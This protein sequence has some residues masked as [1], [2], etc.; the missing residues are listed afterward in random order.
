MKFKKRRALVKE[1]L[2]QKLGLDPAKVDTVDDLKGTVETMKH[3]ELQKLLALL[4][5][6]GKGKAVDL[7]NKLREYLG[8]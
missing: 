2:L 7:R 3:K 4:K 8:Y 5:L 1:L 6:G